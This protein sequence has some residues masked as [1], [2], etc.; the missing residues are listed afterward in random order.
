MVAPTP[1]PI[2][3]GKRDASD[4]SVC[5]SA[6]A[7]CGVGR[8]HLVVGVDAHE[9][10][11]LCRIVERLGPLREIVAGYAEHVPHTDLLQPLVEVGRDRLTRRGRDCLG[12]VL[13][14]E[15]A[16]GEEMGQHGL[17]PPQAVVA[18]GLG[19]ALL[20]RRAGLLA[21]GAVHGLQAEMG[22]DEVG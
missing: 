12:A 1:Y 20:V 8:A 17:G 2:A 6:V 7:V 9:T 5:D 3:V 13:A 4:R 19:R 18:G 16:V 21:G 15:T 10:G 11:V 22:K 14:L